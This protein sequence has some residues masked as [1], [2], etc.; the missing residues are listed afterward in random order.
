MLD[1]ACSKFAS[2]Y[3]PQRS[4]I[5]MDVFKDEIYKGKQNISLYLVVCMCCHLFGLI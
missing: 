5:C 3:Q 2:Q 4:Q 1:I